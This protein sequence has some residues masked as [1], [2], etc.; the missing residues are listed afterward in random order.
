MSYPQ[1]NSATSFPSQYGSDISR[2]AQVIIYLLRLSQTPFKIWY[3]SWTSPRKGKGI[4]KSSWRGPRKGKGVWK[5]SWASPRKGK[6]VWR[7]KI[8]GWPIFIRFFLQI[9]SHWWLLTINWS[10]N[11]TRPPNKF[12][13]NRI[14]NRP[15]FRLSNPPSIPNMWFINPLSRP[16]PPTSPSRN[17]A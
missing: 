4:C 6:G 10:E 5:P 13:S 2:P 7:R 9:M 14:R 11:I 8:H 1:F 3:F 16:R 17:R 12:A 15:P